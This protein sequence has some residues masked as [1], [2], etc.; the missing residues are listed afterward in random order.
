V[1]GELGLGG[2]VAVVTGAGRGF[3][4]RI[5]EELAA[6]GA[7]V[8][9]LDVDAG[10]GERC[11]ERLRAAGGAAVAAAGDVADYDG[12]QAAF[13]EIARALG[14][15]EILVNNAGIVSLTDFLETTVEEFDRVFAVDY[16]G[17]YNCCKAVVPG[18]V[19]RRF[20]RIVNVS[21]IAGKRGG[22]FL[23]RSLYAGAKAGVLGFTKAL[24]R[25][26]A[27]YGILVNAVAPG[28]MDTEMTA[29]LRDDPELLAKVEA[30]I[31]LGYR[32]EVQDVADAVVF[33]VSD[34]AS[35]LTGET[36]DV[37]GGVTME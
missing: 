33:L 5:A 20:G 7:A 14:P 13:A 6:L 10:A 9:V 21:S 27:P 3:G 26:L 28:A 8:G 18:M 35:Y 37:D 1:S 11:A 12:V 31:P 32:G 23:G 34:L 17:P 16:T 30:S 2:R 19:E 29:V 25:E 36:I 22:G 4:E 24:A 15:V